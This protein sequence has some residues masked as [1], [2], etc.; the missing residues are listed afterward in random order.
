MTQ[1]ERK[2]DE[3]KMLYAWLDE[4]IEKKTDVKKNI[5]GEVI[6]DED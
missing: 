3:E 2:L 4:L 6:K 1:L 5:S